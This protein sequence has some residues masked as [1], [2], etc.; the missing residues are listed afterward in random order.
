[1]SRSRRVS[2]G[3]ED[4]SHDGGFTGEDRGPNGHKTSN[5]FRNEGRDGPPAVIA[6]H[7]RVREIYGQ[8]SATRDS[9]FARDAALLGARVGLAWIFIY[10]GGGKLFGLFG[11]G[12]VHQASVFFGT[13]AHLHPAVFFTVL[14]G[15]TEFFG[16]VAVGLGVFGRIAAA[17]LIG[18]MVVAMATVTFGNGIVSN[19]PGGGY[20][21]NLALVALALVVALVGTG[22]FSLD[23]VLRR[24]LMRTP[25]PEPGRVREGPTV[26]AD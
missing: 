14:A 17:G 3:D 15:I 9:R 5:D 7:T 26:R 20:E 24:F 25:L 16:G 13:V 11:G 1:M 18:D 10:N 12:G 19:A 6:V 8:I 4:D 2:E 23:A 22:A 21:L